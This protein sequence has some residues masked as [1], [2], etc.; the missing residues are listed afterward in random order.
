MAD[1]VIGFQ[2]KE[3]ITAGQLGRVIAGIAGSGSYVLE[4]QGKLA[5]TMT[6]ANQVQISTG[7]LVMQGRAVTVETPETLVVDSGVSGQNRNDL[8]VCRYEKNASSGVEK[9]ELKVIK[10]TATADAAADPDYVEGDIVGGDLVAEMPL[11][12]IPISGLAPGDPVPL[13]EYMPSVD[14][15]RDS[16]SQKV[17][18]SWSGTWTSGSITVDGISKCRLALVTILTYNGS[19]TGSDYVLAANTGSGWR[20]I[21]G[22]LWGQSDSANNAA[23]VFFACS[24]SGDTL[25]SPL[26]LKRNVGTGYAYPFRGVSVIE[27]WA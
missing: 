18:A 21:S 4:T 12:R 7:D 2:G 16:L 25:S 22:S 11:Y 15:I 27:A 9:A 14:S 26:A 19:T 5:A 23:E 17:E 10:G 8:V 24:A 3:H 13:F 6:T 20:G 1:L